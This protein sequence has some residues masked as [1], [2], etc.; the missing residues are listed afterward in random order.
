L[1]PS[2]RSPLL[3]G[4]LHV[5]LAS[6]TRSARLGSLDRRAAQSIARLVLGP[7][8]KSS[9]SSDPL[10]R[11]RFRRW[12]ISTAIA[13]ALGFV[14]TVGLSSTAS[15]TA[16]PGRPVVL[17]VHVGRGSLPSTGGA[18]SIVVRTLGASWCALRLVSQPWVHVT[19][20]HR[21]VPCGGGT[22]GTVLRL[23]PNTEPKRQPMVLEVVA[24]NGA[25]I[26]I[27]RFGLSEGPGPQPV[28]PS[29]GS[30]TNVPPPSTGST[31]TSTTVPPQAPSGV[32]RP[33]AIWSG[34]VLP[35][36][37]EVTEANGQWTV[38]A[39]NCL[40]T[41]NAGASTWV[42]IG[43]YAWPS[44][45]TSG[46][47]VQTGI[48]T[49][50]VNGAQQNNAWWEWV[51]SA[52]NES[53][54]FND[55]SVAVGDSITATVFQ[56]TSGQWATRVDDT[57]TG[58]SGEMV[59][60]EGWFLFSDASGAG[61]GAMQGTVPLASLSGC[62]TAEW[63][64]EDYTLGGV[65][66]GAL[67]PFADYGTVSF[68]GLRTSLSSWSLTASDGVEMVQNGVVLSSPSS[69]SGDGF[70]VSYTG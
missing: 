19:F 65:L 15:A 36:S 26:T 52:P 40:T 31:T 6:A 69:P 49:N 41:P 14:G 66:G 7:C 2:T 47:L 61:V 28:A 20:V 64:E 63:I 32:A 68:S 10:A 34:Y 12:V 16:V 56:T 44:G 27:R 23:G 9:M 50:C 37:T 8:R 39:L 18:T 3:G 62:Y 38:P 33:T 59:T 57:T 13:S 11:V 42:G 1:I 5:E 54:Q 51:P 67:V 55:F 4:H 48:T 17:S 70:S 22:M 43:G 45:G 21:A 24:T 58:L 46:P 35:S 29:G 25:R 60:G 30:I 53:R